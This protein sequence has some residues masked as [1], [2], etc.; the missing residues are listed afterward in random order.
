MMT[1]SWRARFTF[2][3]VRGRSEALSRAIWIGRRAAEG[4]YPTLIVGESGTGKELLAH[5]IHN[6]SPLRDGPFVAINCGTLNGELAVAELCGY[7]PGSFTGADRRTHAGIL[8]VARDGTLLLDELQDMPAT[9]QSALLRFLETGTFVRV[10]GT[11][12]VQSSVRVIATLNLAVEEVERRGLVRADLLY[13]LNCVTIEVPPLRAR[14]ED[15]CPIAEKCLREELHFLGE[16]DEPFW[17]AIATCPYGWPGNARGVRNVLL[18]AILTSTAHRLTAA[19]LPAFLW[20]AVAP[21]REAPVRPEGR[22]R[23]HDEV[24]ALRAVLRANRDNVSEA[25]RS[26]G[27]H[28]STVYRRLARSGS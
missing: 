15:I 12:L 20:D 10:G 17:E 8:D 16:V 27:I 2:D 9:A 18:K 24:I 19:D 3:D 7:E 14:R 25:A 1:S 22:T 13:R 28:R 26:P 4:G 6:A 23:N 11:Q 21:G 5:G